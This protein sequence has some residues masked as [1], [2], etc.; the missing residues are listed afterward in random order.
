M[1]VAYASLLIA[2]AF[3]QI[4]SG[5]V[6][7]LIMFSHR[8]TEVTQVAKVSFAWEIVHFLWEVNAQIA[9]LVMVGEEVKK[10][11]MTAD[12]ELDHKKAFKFVTV[13]VI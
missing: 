8:F 5:N 4:I 3:A 12:T 10:T 6:F 7:R 11:S 2:Y 13:S 9:E 1:Y